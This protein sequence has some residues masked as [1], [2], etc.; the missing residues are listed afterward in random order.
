MKDGNYQFQ[1]RSEQSYHDFGCTQ[2]HD[3]RVN[4]ILAKDKLTCVNATSPKVN[5]I[6]YIKNNVVQGNLH[7]YLPYSF[8]LAGNVELIS[9]PT[10]QKLYYPPRPRVV[11]C[12]R[13]A[14]REYEDVYDNSPSRTNIVIPKDV[15]DQPVQLNHVE[16]D[17]QD[18]SIEMDKFRN[19]FEF[20]AQLKVCDISMAP[21]FEKSNAVTATLHMIKGGPEFH[22]L[23][24]Q[25]GECKCKTLKKKNAIKKKSL[26]DTRPRIIVCSN[27]T[28][29]DKEIY[30]SLPNSKR[31]CDTPS[32]V[33]L[34]FL[35]NALN[36]TKFVFGHR[37]HRNDPIIPSF[38]ADLV[39]GF[40]QVAMEKKYKVPLY[41]F[42]PDDVTPIASNL[43]SL[44]IEKQAEFNGA[45]QDLPQ[46]LMEDL[47]QCLSS[48]FLLS[49]TTRIRSLRTVEIAKKHF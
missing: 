13:T 24:S 14:K 42:P 43:H 38:L 9:F 6:V 21:V 44:V 46:G 19:D 36:F 22:C 48:L 15:D 26:S 34:V 37:Y 45:T 32:V 2:K 30:F 40:N 11:Q 4:C 1:T 33:Q 41:I 25:H 20:T 3:P 39:K 17:E 5:Y 12:N 7:K 47:R 28:N 18:L 27:E 8:G 35:L 10:C 29:C 16:I 23:F 49:K 31:V